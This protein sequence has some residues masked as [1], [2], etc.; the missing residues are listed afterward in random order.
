MFAQLLRIGQRRVLRQILRRGDQDAHA[1][2]QLT[3]N[4]TLT[5]VFALAQTQR[6][7][8]LVGHR[9]KAVI[10]RQQLHLNTGVGGHK[11]RQTGG[12]QDI[13]GQFRAAYAHQAGRFSPALVDQLL[14]DLGLVDCRLRMAQQQRTGLR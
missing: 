5:H 10:V 6:H 14:G 13:G 8:N 11:S 12:K 1:L 9:V 2:A 3:G 7:I 4:H